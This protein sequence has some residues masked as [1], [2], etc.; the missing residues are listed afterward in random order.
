MY[1]NMLNLIVIVMPYRIK[2]WLMSMVWKCK[3][4][5]N[6]ELPESKLKLKRL[7]FTWYVLG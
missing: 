3:L 5:P 7:G 4:L 2:L 1:S 6:V